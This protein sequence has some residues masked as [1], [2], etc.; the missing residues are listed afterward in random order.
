M[1]ARARLM[2]LIVLSGLLGLAATAAASEDP[3]T[4]IENANCGM[5][6]QLDSPM[7]GPSY[8]AIAER[9]RGQGE[10]AQEIFDR[11]REGSQGVWGPAPMPP[12]PEASL[13]DD[14][15]RSLVAWMLER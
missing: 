13:S 11:M 1:N 7:L 10:A 12:I 6:H 3:E 4:L 9:Y 2:V 14:E 5:C 8:Q 15:L